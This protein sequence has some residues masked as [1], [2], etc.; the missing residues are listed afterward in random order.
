MPVHGGKRKNA[1]TFRIKNSKKKKYLEKLGICSFSFV[2][3]DNRYNNWVGD[4]VNIVVGMM[5]CVSDRKHFC[6]GG[7]IG[8]NITIDAPHTS[9]NYAKP[10]MERRVPF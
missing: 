3:T 8:L 5:S 1:G 9:L 10:S 7:N 2:L 4:A 6:Y